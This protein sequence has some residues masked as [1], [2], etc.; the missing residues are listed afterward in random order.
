MVN[1]ERPT[2]RKFFALFAAAEPSF[3]RDLSK[4][5]CVC[6]GYGCCCTLYLHFKL[7]LDWIVLLNGKTFVPFATIHK[8]VTLWLCTGFYITFEKLWCVCLKEQQQA[9]LYAVELTQ[10][11]CSPCETKPPLAAIVNGV[12]FFFTACGTAF[13][14][15]HVAFSLGICLQILCPTILRQCTKMLIALHLNAH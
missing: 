12:I 15:C 7:N 10:Q 8:N 6:F 13:T 11:K 4:L 5:C 2:C 9:S 14:R 1:Y 3:G